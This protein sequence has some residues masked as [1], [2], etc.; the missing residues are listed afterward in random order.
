MRVHTHCS[1]SPLLDIVSFFQLS[2]TDCCVMTLNCF[3]LHFLRMSKAIHFFKYL[4]VIFIS[5]FV[6]CLFTPLHPS[7][8]LPG[9]S[10]F[11]WLVSEA[12]Y[13]ILC[14]SLVAQLVK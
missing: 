8:H 13:I 3:N 11:G 12:V 5:L 6:K 1:T 4:F 2:Q 9:L 10:A 7:F 14:A